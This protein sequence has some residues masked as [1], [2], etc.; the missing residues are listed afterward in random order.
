MKPIAI[1]LL[2][3]LPAAIVAGLVEVRLHA[4]PPGQ[5]SVEQ[6]WWVDLTAKADIDTIVWLEGY[7]NEARQGRVFSA[8][9]N[10]FRLTLRTGGK[11]TL[12]L[13]DIRIR[14]QKYKPGY[15]VFYTRSGTI[16]EGDY[17]YYVKLMPDLGEGSRAVKVILPGPPRLVL[18]FDGDTL[19]ERLPSFVWTPPA[20]A[21]KGQ[22]SYRL[23]VVELLESQSKE[24]A[25]AANPPWFEQ[26]GIGR[27]NLRYPVSARSLGTLKKGSG[28]AWQVEAY[29]NNVL[30]GK[31]SISEFWPTLKPTCH[32]DSAYAEGARVEF[33]TYTGLDAA[34]VPF[35]VR[36]WGSSDEGTVTHYHWRVTEAGDPDIIVG[37]G[38]GDEFDIPD[39]GDPRSYLVY[40]TVHCSGGKTRTSAFG[41]NI[42]AD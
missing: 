19:A 14:D 15:E 17:E 13:K 38:I 40:V 20:R 24:E 2:A 18:P 25:I 11:R 3:V 39:L 1:I 21:P 29:Q 27:T 6:L 4:P 23:R 30:L 10:E 34:A 7:V 16:P 9:S 28:F 22:V 41:L 5:F 33:G 31:S 8:R 36:F 42:A 35:D 26:K 12:R 32:V 37:L